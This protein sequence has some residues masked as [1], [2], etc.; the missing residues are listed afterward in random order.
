MYSSYYF[1]HAEVE[2]YEQGADATLDRFGDTQAQTST[3][4]VKL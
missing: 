4:F 3:L 1:I 2:N